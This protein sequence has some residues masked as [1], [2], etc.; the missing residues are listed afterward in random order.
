MNASAVNRRG[1]FLLGRSG[2]FIVNRTRLLAAMGPPIVALGC[3]ADVSRQPLPH[4]H[5]A[6]PAAAVAPAPE[7]SNTLEID[8]A[9][10][11]RPP[12]QPAAEHGGD[13][14]HH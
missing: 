3:A 6:N 12:T 8:Q 11:Q 13:H 1:R 5:P 10:Q 9:R 2:G 4:D 14:A 7:Y